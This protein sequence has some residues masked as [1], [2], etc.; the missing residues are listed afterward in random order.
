MLP[1]LARLADA[2]HE[3]G[4]IPPRADGRRTARLSADAIST[5]HAH[6][7]GLRAVLRKPVEPARLTGTLERWCDAGKEPELSVVGKA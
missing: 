5:E 6:R 1:H 3:R 7:L 2:Q 4:G